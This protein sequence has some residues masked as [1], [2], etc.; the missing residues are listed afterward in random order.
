M[1][2]GV[3]RIAIIDLMFDDLEAQ[4]FENLLPA[5]N[6]F[7][8][9]LKSDTA[10]MNADLRLAKDA[11]LALF[12]LR[13]HV[14]WAKGKVWPAFLAASPEYVLLQD[15]VNVF[16]HGPRRDGQVAKPTDIFETTVIT[17]YEDADGP[18]HVAEKEV[19]VQLRDGSSRDLKVLLRAVLD[20]WIS[21]FKA[22]GLLVNFEAAPP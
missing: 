14:S 3:T 13:E 21:E 8:Q 1:P 4:F 9:S 10:G 12:H 6:A 15:I 7:V 11:A 20:L 17:R 22:R 2:H 16:K 5:Y 19:T 18:Y